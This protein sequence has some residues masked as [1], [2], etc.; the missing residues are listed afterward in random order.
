MQII[1]FRRDVTS[2]KEYYH[3]FASDLHLDAPGFD[4]KVFLQDFDRAKECNARIFINGDVT[5]LLL[6][7][8]KKTVVSEP[9]QG[10]TAGQTQSIRLLRV[11]DARSVCRSH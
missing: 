9:G 3:L 10:S 2:Q 4:K 8:D 6:S 5:S 1:T 7:Q 11:R